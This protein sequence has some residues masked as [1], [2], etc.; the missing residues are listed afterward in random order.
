MLDLRRKDLPD[1]IVIDDKSFPIKTD[2]REWLQFGELIKKQNLR[3]DELYFL[4]K[5]EIPIWDF[6]K[7]LMN[8]YESPEATPRGLMHSGEEKILDMVLDGSY[9]YA[10]FL[11]VYGI[12]IIDIEYMHW[13]KF[14]ALFNGLPDDCCIKNIM[15]IR[16]Y[17]KS[18][19][20]IASLR[21]KLK[22]E[23][24]LEPTSKETSGDIMLEI[25]ELFYNC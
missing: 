10:S 25:N 1:S 4:F 11:A 9:I 7:E 21:E 2:F 22:K 24:A 13:H 17:K 16:S 8:F 5:K 14:L 12:D 18:N 23:W 6:V 3:Y 15:S 20:N 19:S